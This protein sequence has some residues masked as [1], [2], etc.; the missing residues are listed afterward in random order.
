MQKTLRL[1]SR[2]KI[3]SFKEANQTEPTESEMDQDNDKDN[4]QRTETDFSFIMPT[5]YAE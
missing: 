2:G 1:R 5:L 3:T 4:L